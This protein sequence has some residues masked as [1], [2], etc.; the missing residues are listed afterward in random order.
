MD[1]VEAHVAGLHFA[2]NRVQICPV[3]IQQ[4]ARIVYDFLDSLNLL[5]KHAQCG[6]IGQHQ[7]CGLRA[8]GGAQRIKVNVAVV[9][10]GNLFH[11]VAAH[12][13]RR[14]ISAVRRI[15]HDDLGARLVAARFVIGADHRDTSELA[16]CA[17]HWRQAH[18]CHA[19]HVLQNFLQII[20]ASEKALSGGIRRQRMACQ[21]IG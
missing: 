17:R 9:V 14:G 1:H 15:R 4:A 19:G 5:L 20:Q 11:G 7:A 16:L 10:S 2:E 8:D 18:A 6:R 13:R 21:K 3:V 12:H